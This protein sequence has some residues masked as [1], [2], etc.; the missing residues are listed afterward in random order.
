M[1]P[2]LIHRPM[3]LIGS[4]RNPQSEMYTG[5]RTI[6][7]PV[8]PVPPMP[9]IPPQP[10]APLSST[11]QTRSSPAPA[12]RWDT[13]R[14]AVYNRSPSSSPAPT[15]VS[16]TPDSTSQVSSPHL[17]ATATLRITPATSVSTA[18][19]HN[20][21]AG[22]SIPRTGSALSHLSDTNLAVQSNTSGT[23]LLASPAASTLSIS[24][25]NLT[26]GSSTT[27]THVSRTRAVT[28]FLNVVDQA[29]SGMAH[30]RSGVTGMGGSLMFGGGSS[31]TKKDSKAAAAIISALE[32]DEASPFAKDI[33]RVCLMAKYNSTHKSEGPAHTMPS[34]SVPAPLL[35]AGV[36]TVTVAGFLRSVKKGPSD[37]YA[38]V[39]ESEQS[40]AGSN[41][42]RN[43]RRGDSSSS[44]VVTL[45]ELH[46]LVVNAASTPEGRSIHLPLHSMVLSTL[47]L[48][49]ILNI[50]SQNLSFH[51][52][53]ISSDE[54]RRRL[55]AERRKEVENE[56]WL[57][58]ETFQL[59]AKTW[60]PKDERAEVERWMWCSTAAGAGIWTE[61]RQSPL[62]VNGK[63]RVHLLGILEGL[64][65]P[66][67]GALT[68]STPGPDRQGGLG[69]GIGL[70]SMRADSNM[71]TPQRSRTLDP[72]AV[73]SPLTIPQ[74][75]QSL[76]Q[77]LYRIF[78]LANSN[79]PDAE[80]L[81][82][83]LNQI[84]V[85]LE[86]GTRS[87]LPNHSPHPPLSLKHIED[88]FGILA[89][90]SDQAEDFREII[91]FEALLKM[92]E[93][94]EESHRRWFFANVVETR[95][96]MSRPTRQLSPLWVHTE[97]RKL[98]AFLRASLSFIQT[99]FSSL[100]E[101]SDS[102]LLPFH[103]TC[104]AIFSIVRNRV[105]DAIAILQ[106]DI[107]DI[108]EQ[109]SESS[110]SVNE[111]VIGQLQELVV[112]V[113][114][115]MLGLSG[116]AYRAQL[117]IEDWSRD[118]LWKDLFQ[119][120]IKGMHLTKSPP[121][122][123]STD[124]TD[125]LRALS[126][127]YPRHFFGPLFACARSN[128][129]STIT[130][131][132][133]T[134]TAIARYLP[135]FWIADSEMMCIALMSE[136]GVV[137]IGGGVAN[138]GAKGKGKVGEPP[139]WG[140]ARLGQCVL[141]LELIGMIRELGDG[142]R[143][144]SKEST[145]FIS[146]AVSFFTA[147][148]A[149]IAVLL[150]VKELTTLSPFSMRLLISTLIL[151]IRLFTRSLK[152]AQWLSRIV[153]WGCTFHPGAKIS[154]GEGAPNDSMAL[155]WTPI[156]D[157][158]ITESDTTLSSI[159]ALYTNSWLELPVT[160]NADMLSTPAIGKE[161]WGGVVKSPELA[162][163]LTILASLQPPPLAVFQL[164][165]AVSAVLRSEDIS[166]LGPILW[167]H[168]LDGADASALGPVAYLI[169]QS[170]EK[171]YSSA[172]VA[173]VR[174]D[175]LG[176][177][178]FL[179]RRAIG[180]LTKLFS[181]R[182]QILTQA[183]I[184]DRAHRRPFRSGRPPLA[185]VPTDIGSI[186]FIPGRIQEREHISFASS[187]P[188]EVRRRLVELG[189]DTD[190]SSSPEGLAKEIPPLSVAPS[191]RL[192]VHD[193]SS[194][195]LMG[196]SSTRGLL[197]RKSSGGGQGGKK[198]PIFVAALSSELLAVLHL[199]FS[200][201]IE[202]SSAAR[203]LILDILRDDPGL[204]LRPLLERLSD[205]EDIS[206]S[207]L[208]LEKT[209]QL[210]ARLPFMLTH[211]VFN[212]LA[213]LL[214][215]L[216]R[217]PTVSMSPIVYAY[218]LS[219]IANSAS[220]V[221]GIA[222]RELR[223]SKLDPMLLP[224]GSLWFSDTMF[225]GPMF[226]RGLPLDYVPSQ[227]LPPSLVMITMVRTAQNTLLTNLLQ[228]DHKEV[229]SIRRS[230]T[231]LTLPTLE[232]LDEEEKK[233]L[234]NFSPS[235]SIST[236]I[237]HSVEKKNLRLL[238]LA[239]A[240]SY[241]LLVAQIFRC[242]SRQ[243]NDYQ[244]I[245]QLLDGVNRILI[246]HGSDIGIVS[247]AMINY[248]IAMTRF[249]RLF[250][251]NGGFILIMPAVWKTYCAAEGGNNAIR[252]AIEYAV[253]R[254]HA[255]HMDAFV[256]Q[257]VDV[258]A[259]MLAHPVTQGQETFASNFTALFLSLSAA[260]RG[261][262]NAG[263]IQNTTRPYE[264]EAIVSNLNEDPD[265]LI[266][267]MQ[268]GGTIS[269]VVDQ[270]EGKIFPLENLARL[271]LT[272]IADDPA[273]LRA[274]QFLKLFR[275][276]APPLY[277]RSM[278]ARTFIRDGI[279]A[280]GRSVFSRAAPSRVD[281]RTRADD[282]QAV[283][284]S[285]SL[286]AEA[287][288]DREDS[289]FGKANSPS[290]FSTM[291]KDY[292]YLM[293][294][295][296]K[297][298]GELSP[299]VT[300]RGLE[301]LKALLRN[302]PGLNTKGISLFLR[303]L[304]FSSLLREGRLASPKQAVNLL[305]DI[306]P[307]ISSYGPAI[308]FTGVYEVLTKLC[309]DDQYTSDPT[310]TYMAVKGYIETGINCFEAAAEANNLVG[311]QFQ[312]AFVSFMIQLAQV[313]SVDAVGCLTSRLPSSGLL[314]S[315]AL[316]LCLQLPI[317]A[318]SQRRLTSLRQS[319]VL[320]LGFG[321]RA[322]SYR[323]QVRSPNSDRKTSTAQERERTPREM[324]STQLLGLQLIKV[325]MVRAGE[326]LSKVMPEAWLRISAVVKEELVDGDG[327]FMS[328]GSTEKETTPTQSPATSRPSTPN[329]QTEYAGGAAQEKAPRAV[330]YATW[331][332]MEFVC[333][334]RTPLSIQ[335]RLWVQEKLT[336]LEARFEASGQ[337]STQRRSLLRDQ[338]RLSFSPFTK[339]RRR[340]GNLSVPPSPEISP[341]F[342]PR[343]M[344]T[345]GVPPNLLLGSASSI[346]TF[347]RFPQASP[348]ADSR[349]ARIRHLGPEFPI[350]EAKR[351]TGPANPLRAA[352][353]SIPIGRTRLVQES[354]RRV[355]AVRI[356]WGYETFTGDDMSSFE[357]WSM[358]IALRRI[359]EESKELMGEFQDV[360]RVSLDE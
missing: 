71:S 51:Q 256:F 118:A 168:H 204:F 140:T 53:K 127:S 109:T 199:A 190:A 115:E 200:E 44:F 25:G 145:A 177:S 279:D 329:Q 138:A 134:I 6:P 340:S 102:N 105:I 87:T 92:L 107:Q 213:G 143:D 334:Y 301:I 28:N 296:I 36:G 133:Q 248:M 208:R 165:V 197:R 323:V 281:G 294:A 357:A 181:W 27:A 324:V 344:S 18:S 258:A 111:A 2:T 121:L 278:Q 12:K 135:T 128:N 234:V 277:E 253:N 300:G 108:H 70:N 1:P 74:V 262:I 76:L 160:P 209:L 360:S 352:S 120:A 103:N 161:G 155:S 270:Y 303:E 211:M 355:H 38:S 144:T 315:L 229:H 212:H 280:L 162:R 237:A 292:L 332:L 353:K 297:A 24:S 175:L 225:P 7:P 231:T 275:Y 72:E 295:Y 343:G 37:G 93:V 157:E 282:Q 321:I 186:N 198:R 147:L 244:E 182:Y 88:E 117:M 314:A 318:S 268:A 224:T 31:H 22:F 223:K 68:K 351:A 206:S 316:P 85:A 260:L 81:R 235:V 183:I 272:V 346:S 84:V 172:A 264:E 354:H 65:A 151:E 349:I 293:V 132:L 17:A 94:G 167:N 176:E 43:A 164:L 241:L 337:V 320:L 193:R 313:D 101:D 41:A 5:G 319:W 10:D 228:R 220:Q 246:R 287:R 341:S 251:S 110:A 95:W 55:E 130:T 245:S 178:D 4:S 217:D 66:K 34:T 150:N 195:S 48:P 124:V 19:N 350:R 131:H 284:L 139:K 194:S 232:A 333:F 119:A 203:C 126:Q 226:P 219:P 311:I 96:P 52:E 305:N 16:I 29:R 152:P 35:T 86:K 47:L 347:D 342:R 129:V 189:W 309:T 82:E 104:S 255:I 322:A 83:P 326:E 3:D 205:L 345:I 75:L 240:R 77:S 250:S 40:G 78:P 73:S 185:Y 269:T 11:N 358:S 331:S 158:I 49:F 238:S 249:R 154:S 336:A 156:T 14:R 64:L 252:G 122:L 163:S 32:G 257:A 276:V 236:S 113:T 59:I 159:R 265:I 196:D 192:T 58:V 89:L 21:A 141:F 302:N 308:D 304:T 39:S 166:R 20:A 90:P 243:T 106:G 171:G 210:Q 338:R 283:P 112:K 348:P 57:A 290:S 26:H 116:E 216:S 261:D 222:I 291:R 146:Q 317:T 306:T 153:D 221:S 100:K 310:F 180:R 142:K 173:A 179:K 62:H 63:L 187:L 201:E 174:A 114:I 298:G 42:A 327:A 149:R 259:G 289:T 30:A 97:N 230:F 288:L 214:K 328:T 191:D 263:G 137:G 207:I 299:E 67:S 227:H 233:L 215:T 330:D 136:A 148:E 286:G 99:S 33:L 23:N 50:S 247:H 218:S 60:A 13:V 9:S 61:R 54:V 15:T 123:P 69:L 285:R 239:L 45:R 274:E 254:F 80:N 56:Q 202:V 79:V 46:H 267:S 273:I 8:P 312:Q 266:N 169:M 339:A 335:L 307:L 325:I 188:P 271:F 242:L 356:F 98:H 184:T 359:V 125:L 91:C 170:A